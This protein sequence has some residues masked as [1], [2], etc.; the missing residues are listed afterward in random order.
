MVNHLFYFRKQREQE[1]TSLP[2]KNQGRG[3]GKIYISSLELL[4]SFPVMNS[5][6]FERTKREIKEFLKAI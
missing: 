2:A 3:V 4:P 5:V 1:S 6:G